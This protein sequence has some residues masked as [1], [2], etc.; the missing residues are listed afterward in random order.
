MDTTRKI[1]YRASSIE[2]P[3]VGAASRAALRLQQRPPRLG[4][5]T[6]FT[7]VELLVVITIIG[8]LVALITVAA[9]GALRAAREAAIKT[10]INQMDQ[11]FDEYKNKTT[12]LPPNCQTDGSGN[13]NPLNE[14]IIAQD[15]QRHLKQAFP[16][17]QEPQEL[18]AKLAGLAT[19]S[20]GQQLTGGMAAGEALVFWLGG[21]SSDPKY[22]ISGEGGPAYK[23]ES[24]GNAQNRALDPIDT[25]NWV[26]PFEV[27]RLGPRTDDKY[28]DDSGKRFIEY[29]VSINGQQQF[30]RINFWQYSP[31]RS[32]QPYLYFDTSRHPPRPEFD[33]PAATPLTMLGEDGEGLHVHALKKKSASANSDLPIQFIDPNGFQILHCGDDDA[34]GEADFERTSAHSVTDASL[35]LLFPDGPFTGE[36]AD[37]IVNFTTERRLEDAQP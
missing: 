31:R 30:R 1:Q 4:G 7:L 37:T 11:A 20:N 26:F 10:E 29:T 28:F 14:A 34:W 22:P 17:H 18:I 12:A 25:R 15:L 27:P 2:H 32:T 6:A 19:G 9:I 23:I 35:Y 3:H 16:R 8:I 21:F 5:P 13:A 24:I 33:P 36:I